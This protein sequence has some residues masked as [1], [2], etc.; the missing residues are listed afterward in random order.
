MQKRELGQAGLE[1]SAIGLGCMGM[2][3]S[4]GPAREAIDCFHL[5]ALKRCFGNL[6]DVLGA[7]VEDGPP[8]GITWIRP[9][10]ELC[11]D[12]DLAAKRAQT[13]VSGRRFAVL[14]IRA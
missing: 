4:Y 11:R 2:S 12:D 1:V 14:Q 6:L 7:A 9:P 13:T 5:Q 8:V 10:S 3:W